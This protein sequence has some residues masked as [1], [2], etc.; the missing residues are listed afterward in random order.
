MWDGVSATA[1]EQLDKD[2]AAKTVSVGS[3]ADFAGVAA[4]INAGELR[5]YTITLQTNIDLNEKAWAPIS[6]G[7]RVGGS[8]TGE[9]AFAG[10]FYPHAHIQEEKEVNTQ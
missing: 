8:Y 2:D 10:T 7:T 3:A 4:A 6:S 5:G 9:N 1:F